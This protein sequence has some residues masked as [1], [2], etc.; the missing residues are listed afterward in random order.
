MSKGMGTLRKIERLERANNSVNG[1]PAWLVTF[2]DGETLRTSSD[3]AVGYEI[4]NQGYRPGC[5]VEV[6]TTRA[7]R[8]TY[9]NAV[10]AVFVP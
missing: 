4:G 6:F 10:F 2:G 1:N 3:A 7:G 5:A 9:M 8:I